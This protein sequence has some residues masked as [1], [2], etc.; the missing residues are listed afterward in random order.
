[1]VSLLQLN[2]EYAFD[3]FTPII[4]SQEANVFFFGISCR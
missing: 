1:V 2:L 4:Q 3:I